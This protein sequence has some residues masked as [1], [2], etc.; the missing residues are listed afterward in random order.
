MKKGLRCLKS[1]PEMVVG[2]SRKGVYVQTK[3]C[4]SLLELKA[5]GRGDCLLLAPFSL[6]WRI[7]VLQEKQNVSSFGMESSL[8]F[9]SELVL[10]DQDRLFDVSLNLLTAS[11]QSPGGKESTRG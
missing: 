8:M 1:D 10:P 5:L 3:G 6:L 11:H 4:E 7:N 2:W 9:M